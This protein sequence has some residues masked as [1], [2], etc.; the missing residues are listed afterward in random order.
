MIL[1]LLGIRSLQIHL[2]LT[3][4]IKC[5]PLPSTFSEYILRNTFSWRPIFRCTKNCT[6]LDRDQNIQAVHQCHQSFL[7][8]KRRKEKSKHFISN[9]TLSL[10]HRRSLLC[11]QHWVC[12]P[13]GGTQS[14][15]Y[16]GYTTFCEGTEHSRLM[17]W[18]SRSSLLMGNWSPLTLRWKISP[19]LS[20]PYFFSFSRRRKTSLI[21][22][23]FLWGCENLLPE[24]LW[25]TEWAQLFQN[26]QGLHHVQP[27]FSSMS[28]GWRC[29]YALQTVYTCK[30]KQRKTSWKICLRKM[31]STSL[32]Q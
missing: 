17:N 7:H 1:Y 2:L 18:S 31:F 24:S 11:S 19:V 9:R 30:R 27:L 29:I 13:P 5:A 14:Q 28:P 15:A 23:K 6:D 10:E 22:I 3:F 16:Q 32:L 25:R 26:Q 8:L 21:T 12:P 20:A 4:L